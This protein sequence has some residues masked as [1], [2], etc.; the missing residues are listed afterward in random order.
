MTLKKFAG[1]FTNRMKVVEDTQEDLK[2]FVSYIATQNI[3][4]GEHKFACVKMRERLLSRKYK[5]VRTELVFWK[6]E[7]ME[8]GTFVVSIDSTVNKLRKPQIKYKN[9]RNIMLREGTD[10]D[11]MYVYIVAEF[12]EKFPMYNHLLN[13]AFR[14]R[15]KDGNIIG[16]SQELGEVVPLDEIQEM[17][18]AL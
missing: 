9:C 7:D 8:E 5:T 6:E 11:V 2:D 4:L 12:E 15:D 1:L 3:V 14:A 16:E 10:E 13:M 18:I 17:Q